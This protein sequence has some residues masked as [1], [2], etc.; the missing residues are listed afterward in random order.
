MLN[1]HASLLPKYRGASPI[2][3]ALSNG[4]TETGVSI[5]RILPKKFDI[6]E[7]YATRKVEITSDMLMP[8][9]HNVLSSAGAELLAE[10][11]NN[12]KQIRPIAQ[13]DSKATYGEIFPNNLSHLS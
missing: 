1:L 5:M 10:T 2:I 9:L 7:I 12:F 8:E 6:G 4:E 13:D 11:I 3:Y